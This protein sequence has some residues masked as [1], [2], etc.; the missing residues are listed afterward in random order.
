VDSVVDKTLIVAR[1]M[2]R[3]QEEDRRESS[4]LNPVMV[5]GTAGC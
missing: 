2:G 4:I 1:V 3:C 5:L